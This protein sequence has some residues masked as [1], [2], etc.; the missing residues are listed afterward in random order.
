MADVNTEYSIWKRDK[1]WD[2]SVLLSSRHNIIMM[3]LVRLLLLV[4]IEILQNHNK[5]YCNIKIQYVYTWIYLITPHHQWYICYDYSYFWL[6][7]IFFSLPLER[8]SVYGWMD[9]YKQTYIIF[10][11][12]SWKVTNLHRDTD[13]ICGCKTSFM[14]PYKII[15]NLNSNGWNSEYIIQTE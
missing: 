12:I 9:G 8:C 1:D 7:V 5:T 14:L 6:C 4:S 10:L 13:A 15:K 11:I 3:N 2:E